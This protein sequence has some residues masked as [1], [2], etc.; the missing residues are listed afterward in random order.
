MRV[1]SDTKRQAILDAAAEGFR[2]LGVERTSMS[3]IA[4]RVGGSK[5]TLYSYFAS[6]EELVLEILLAIGE[7]HGKQAYAALKAAP[8]IRT[9]L[10]DFGVGHLKFVTNP[11]T[12]A[13][14]RLA[15]AEG[16]R[17]GL[18]RQFYER[19]PRQ[20]LLELSIYLQELIDRGELS[21]GNAAQMACHLKALYEAEIFD[22][23]LFGAIDS[24]E[25][26]DLEVIARRAVEA[27]LSLYGRQAASDGTIRS[28]ISS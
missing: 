18:G 28:P 8:D 14:I 23:H 4:A 2:E 20:L 13:I 9:G 11:D 25:D 19:G 5:A 27:F 17:S 21:N 6:K 7:Q 16:G 12:M 15:I 24:K 26:T 22:Q 10:T 3:E 1:K